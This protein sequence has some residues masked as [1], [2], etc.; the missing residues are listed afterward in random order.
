RFELPLKR[1]SHLNPVL[2]QIVYCRHS[3]TSPVFA[4]HSRKIAPARGHVKGPDFG[5]SRRYS[6][7]SAFKSSSGMDAAAALAA[8]AFRSLTPGPSPFSSTKITLADSRAARFAILL[9]LR[10]VRLAS[11]RR[12]ELS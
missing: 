4:K 10:I 12:L 9:Q 6:S 7:F 1:R 11:T 8:L 2:N 3:A 5:P